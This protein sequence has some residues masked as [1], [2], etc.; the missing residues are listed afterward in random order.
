MLEI[1]QTWP[2]VTIF[3]Y[4]NLLY[5]HLLKNSWLNQVLQGTCYLHNLHECLEYCTRM[6]GYIRNDLFI[7]RTAL[8]KL[9]INKSLALNLNLWGNI[10]L[11]PWLGCASWFLF[12]LFFFFFIIIYLF[13]SSSSTFY[14]SLQVYF[15]YFHTRRIPLILHYLYEFLLPVNLQCNKH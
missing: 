10:E 12:F 15:L 14:G 8:I 13:S 2:S 4:I 3:A 1:F 6:Y 7:T 11:S 9:R 5:F